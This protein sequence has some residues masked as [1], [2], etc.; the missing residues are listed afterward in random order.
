VCNLFARDPG[1]NTHLMVCKNTH[2]F[3]KHAL[4]CV[5]LATS[6]K[7]KKT[8]LKACFFTHLYL[9]NTQL[10]WKIHT[11]ACVKKHAL[12]CVNLATEG[13]LKIHTL[14][15]RV[16]IYDRFYTN[17][18]TAV[19]TK[20]RLYP[21]T[22]VV[23]SLESGCSMH[24]AVCGIL[25]V[26]GRLIQSN[27]T[28]SRDCMFW[29][30]LPK[31]KGSQHSQYVSVF[32]RKTLRIT[33]TGPTWLHFSQLLLVRPKNVYNLHSEFPCIKI[34]HLMEITTIT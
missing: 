32:F 10:L 16:C 25:R 29:L 17:F 21:R 4:R 2:L 6:E 26:F 28:R 13:V 7:R 8:H 3:E 1:Q 22:S 12:R 9:A 11:L 31:G 34:L 23:A 18:N 19:P 27:R 20:N 15:F 33:A 14:F 5:N 24:F 30:L